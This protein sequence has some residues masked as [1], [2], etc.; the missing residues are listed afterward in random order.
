MD[1]NGDS[2]VVQKGDSSQS[3]F[4][5][6]TKLRVGIMLDTYRVEAWDFTML[7]AITLSDYASIELVI[8]HE[9]QDEK[10]LYRDKILSDWNT[11]LYRAY[12]KFEDR[13]SQPKPALTPMD[14]SILLKHVPV[15]GIKPDTDKNSD[16]FQQQDI[17]KIQRI[18]SRCNRKMR[19]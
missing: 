8:F 15:I 19:I 4:K 16:W 18:Q 3:V 12:T 11:L 9:S 17:E 1:N 13:I 7:E 14:A 6:I 2:H 10:K 5:N